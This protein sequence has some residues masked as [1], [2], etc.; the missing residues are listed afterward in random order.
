MVYILIDSNI[1][2][3]TR[4]VSRRFGKVRI[5]V[6]ICAEVPEDTHLRILGRN[7]LFMGTIL[8]LYQAMT[9]SFRAV[10]LWCVSVS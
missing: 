8:M 2:I 7:G 5:L 1:G 4:G 10:V 9:Q 6:E 3:P